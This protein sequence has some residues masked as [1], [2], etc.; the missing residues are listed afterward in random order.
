MFTGRTLNGPYAPDVLQTLILQVSTSNAS[1]KSTAETLADGDWH[2]FTLTTNAARIRGYNIFLDGQL[3][4]T[5]LPNRTYTS[6]LLRDRFC[7]LHMSPMPLTFEATTS[8]WT[9][10]WSDPAAANCTY[11][12]PQC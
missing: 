7:N 10:S 4:G 5:L 1:N 9:G 3:V 6:A 8:S 2:M 11:T 12:S